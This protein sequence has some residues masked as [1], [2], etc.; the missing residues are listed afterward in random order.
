[1]REHNIFKV[2][3]MTFLLLGTTCL[4]SGFLYADSKIPVLVFAPEGSRGVASTARNRINQYFRALLEIDK[5]IQLREP[6][7]GMVVPPQPVQQAP[8]KKVV[9]HRIE[10]AQRL[11]DKGKRLINKRRYEEAVRAL[12]QGTNI[13]EHNLADLEDFD[14]YVQAKLELAVAFAMADYMDEAAASIR[15]VLTVRPDFFL[16][17][18][19]YPKRFV[20]FFNRIR[21]HFSKHTGGEVDVL[22]NSSDARIYC[23]GNLAGTGSATIKGLHRGRHYVRIVSDGYKNRAIRIYTPIA[24]K[25]TIHVRLRPLKGKARKRAG[26]NKFDLAGNLAALQK[27]VQL[28]K[29]DRRFK[30]VARRLTDHYKTPFLLVGYIAHADQA[31]HL[32]VFVYRR[33]DNQIFQLNPA[34][35]SDDMSNLQVAVLDLESSLS[36]FVT[37]QA[38]A[39]AVTSRPAIYA[40]VP[41]PPPPPAPVAKPAPLPKPVVV[42]QPKPKPRVVTTPPPPPAPAVTVRP[43]PAPRAA[44]PS[45]HITELPAGFP[46]TG[47]EGPAIEKPW[48]KKWWVWTIVGVAVVGAG[49]GTYFGVSASH[50]SSGF[51]AHVNWTPY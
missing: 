44:T 5:A 43:T 46:M 38:K 18:G 36:K 10:R 3:G 49:V 7:P 30:T 29:F 17:K 32:A 20:K 34:L 6:K 13:L 14:V 26:S 40:L 45:V 2:F 15:T 28:G 33:K 21:T 4:G 9:N 27:L 24:G 31:F 19:Q 11:I 47:A 37:G 23:D 39:Q 41:P 1:M 42:T 16:D 8:V 35:I 51:S 12:Y 50:G 22:T 48:Y 25:K